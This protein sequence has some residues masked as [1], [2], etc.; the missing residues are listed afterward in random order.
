MGGNLVALRQVLRADQLSRA[1]PRAAPRLGLDELEARL[2][3]LS[4]QGG[5]ARYTLASHLLVAAQ[6]EGGPVAWI[7]LRDD[8]PFPPDLAR[9][10]A[11][12]AA[13]PFVR[14]ADPVQA[15]RAAI[16]LARSG[17]FRLLVVDLLGAGEDARMPVGALSRLAG[18]AR[19]HEMVLLLLTTK[20][21]G[22]GSLHSLISL[23]AEALRERARGRRHRCTFRAIKDKQ[24]GPGWSTT[25]LC[26][27]P[28]GLA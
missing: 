24:R 25:L 5:T 17:A 6:R 22:Q 12:L 11:D 23:R 7:H 4:G 26:E 2:V 1:R 9:A 14:A 28:E 16:T 21:A 13:L 3:E 18:L 8:G 19:A 27:P 10:G 15:A 20:G